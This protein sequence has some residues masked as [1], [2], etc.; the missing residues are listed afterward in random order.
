[1]SVWS[2]GVSS[3]LYR[4]WLVS[5]RGIF[6]RS[7]PAPPSSAFNAPTREDWADAI[8]L[9]AR[10]CPRYGRTWADPAAPHPTLLAGFLGLELDPRV[11]WPIFWYLIGLLYLSCLF[12]YRPDVTLQFFYSFGP[13]MM[14]FL[15]YPTKHLNPP[16]L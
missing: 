12:C 14:C 4:R 11:C 15:I 8:E 3:S 6:P 1:M 16:K 13:I 5:S 9:G 7:T 10:S 2:E